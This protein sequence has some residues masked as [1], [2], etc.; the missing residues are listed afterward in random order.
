M[1]VRQRPFALPCFVLSYLLLSSSL[2]ITF[3]FFSSLSLFLSSPLF[4]SFSF[5]P[6]FFV[7]STSLS[8]RFFSFFSFFLIFF[9][10]LSSSFNGLRCI[11]FLHHCYFCL[12]IP[13]LVHV[14]MIVRIIKNHKSTKMNH[15]M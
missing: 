2:L 7:T 4:S 8:H 14:K 5:C 12:A 6:Y 9:F 11:A 15:L 10:T 13:H 3:L 1:Q